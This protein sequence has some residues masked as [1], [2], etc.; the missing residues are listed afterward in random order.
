MSDMADVLSY[1][2]RKAKANRSLG[3]EVVHRISTQLDLID[4]SIRMMRIPKRCPRHP[5]ALG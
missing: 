5:F 2:I 3:I 4:T 1:V